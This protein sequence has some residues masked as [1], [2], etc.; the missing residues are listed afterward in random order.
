M[1]RDRQKKYYERQKTHARFKRL[2]RFEDDE[3]MLC[4]GTACSSVA[5]AP[6]ALRFPI[7]RLQERNQT[8]PVER[9]ALLERV[10][11]EVDVLCVCLN[12]CHAVCKM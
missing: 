7:Y 5:S 8:V 1:Q 4:A 9:Q 10:L 11:A 12:P 2:K 3:I 6:H